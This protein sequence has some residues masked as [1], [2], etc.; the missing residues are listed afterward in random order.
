M[1]D[2]FCCNYIL[3]RLATTSR[4]T[5]GPIKDYPVDFIEEIA[6]KIIIMK[7]TIIETTVTNVSDWKICKISKNTFFHGTPPV[8]ASKHL[9]TL[10][11]HTRIKL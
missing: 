4:D 9:E 10:R 2:D 8:V 6:M 1:K 11:L 3:H 5:S 7:S